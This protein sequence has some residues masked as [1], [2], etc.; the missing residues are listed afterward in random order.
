[1]GRGEG[2]EGAQAFQQL[3]RRHRQV[4]RQRKLT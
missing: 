1:L 4:R 2:I 3:D